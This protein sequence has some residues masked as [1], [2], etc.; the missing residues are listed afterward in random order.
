M[1]IKLAVAASAALTAAWGAV[2]VALPTGA[3]PCEA[4]V[5]PCNYAHLYSGSFSWQSELLG[6]YGQNRRSVTVT[7]VKGTA[8]CDGSETDVNISKV[9]DQTYTTTEVGTIKGPGLIAVEFENDSAGAVIYRVTGACPS[10]RWEAARQSPVQPAELGN[11]Y[12]EES[13]NQPASAMWIDLVGNRSELHPDTDQV[14]GVSGTI[15]VTWSL[16]RS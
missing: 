9:G 14:N 12:E 16:K 1:A 11:S 5:V 15:R 7:V 4:K 6:P 8:T 3:E 2:T 10:P 13:Y